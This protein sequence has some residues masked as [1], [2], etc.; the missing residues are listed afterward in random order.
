MKTK[1]TVWLIKKI[2]Q[3]WS[4]KSMSSGSVWY[5]TNTRQILFILK[6]YIYKQKKLKIYL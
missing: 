3:K 5:L 6:I 2:N 1:A 4:M